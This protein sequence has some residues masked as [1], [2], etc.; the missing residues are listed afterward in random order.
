MFARKSRGIL[1]V[2]YPGFYPIVFIIILSFTLSLL[3][4]GVVGAAF[5]KLFPDL[6]PWAALILLGGCLMGSYINIPVTRIRAKNPIIRVRRVRVFGVIYHVPIIAIGVDEVL[7]VVNVGGAVIPA[8][9]SIYLLS[10]TPQITLE[11]LLAITSVAI[12]VKLVSR[13][14]R[15]IG[16]VAPSLVPPLFAALAT[17]LIAAE[18]AHIIAYVS[19][20]LGTLIG[21][22][23]MN[24]RAFS[25]LGSP[26]ISI[27]GAG[28]FD[29]IFLSGIMA[30]LIAS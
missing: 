6:G 23:L 8:A 15:G 21:A 18:N 12:A 17:M 9:A 27:G 2:P 7:L 4:L 30:V 10:Q 1:Y 11:A 20:T 25:K 13:P 29:G 19:G 24:F 14:V 3:F 5:K 22:D 28:T 16:I 26:I